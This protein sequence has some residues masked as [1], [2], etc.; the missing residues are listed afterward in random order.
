MPHCP[1]CLD[2]TCVK[3]G[4]VKGK[5]RYVCKQCH[6]RHTVRHRGGSPEHKRQALQ[7]YLEGLGLRSIGRVLR[8]SYVAGY[9][10]IRALG[11][12]LEP[13]KSASGIPVVEMD[14]LQ[15]YVGP[16]KPVLDLDGC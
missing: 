3:D 4:V 14:E 9:R 15:S 13:L 16:K 5:H 12:Q 2:G 1:K 6:Y 8:V 10:W 11:A 7:R